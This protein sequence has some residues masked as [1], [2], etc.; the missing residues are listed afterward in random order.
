MKISDKKTVFKGFYEVTAVKVIDEKNNK[1]IDREQFNLFNSVAAL[2]LNTTTNEVI[3]VK[4]FRVGAEKE[5][6]EIPA[7]KRDV[8]GESA[9]ET[10]KREI[11]EEIG[12]QT[13]ELARIACFYTTPGPVTEKMT[14]F[15]AKVSHQISDG[16]GVAGES[17]NI[18]VVKIKKEEFLSTIYEDAK[19]IIAQQWLQIHA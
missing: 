15:F 10:V 17:E 7:G 12:Y 13:D 16:G 14:L 9:E 19:T 18:E 1:T 6:I 4:Q 2:V 3:L 5:L 11:E 8:E